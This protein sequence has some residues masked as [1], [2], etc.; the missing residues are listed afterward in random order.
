MKRGTP[1]HPKTLQFAELLKVRRAHAVGYLELLF[2]F[3]AQYA[4][5]GDV[6]RFT[7]KRISGGLDWA[8]KPERI[9]N[10]LI[11]S[12]W[13]DRD[14]VSRLVVHDWE[15]HALES[16]KRGRRG[17][18]RGST[19]AQLISGDA[20]LISGDDFRK[21]PPLQN[22]SDVSKLS[23]RNPLP[24]PLPKPKPEPKP[25]VGK[26][27]PQFDSQMAAQGVMIEC[28]IRGKE[29]PALL[30]E[31]I[32]DEEKAGATPEETMRAMIA[33]WQEFESIPAVALEF[34]WGAEKFFG[35]GNWRNRHKWP[36]KPGQEPKPK[37]RSLSEQI[38]EDRAREK[39]AGV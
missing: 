4:P 36:W 28:R 35:G 23:G 12:G 3:A 13:L 29:L 33:A 20:E 34:T 8:G 14:P 19:D 11:E 37:S 26:T 38:L 1:W 21:M 30:S 10:A 15:D 27:P 6:G 17:A 25:A 32:R 5:H 39:A 31:V 7:D 18:R 16:V 24:L 22:Q 9:I 2:H